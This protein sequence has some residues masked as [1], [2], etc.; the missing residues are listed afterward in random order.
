MLLFIGVRPILPVVFLFDSRSA[1]VEPLDSP[2]VAS[3]TSHNNPSAL[4]SNTHG[5]S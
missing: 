1:L 2:V 4:R 3:C 5:P